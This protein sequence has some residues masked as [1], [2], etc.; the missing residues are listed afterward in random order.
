LLTVWLCAAFSSD[1]EAQLEWI[2]RKPFDDGGLSK[3]SHLSVG[4]SASDVILEFGP[5]YTNCIMLY[6]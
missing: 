3:Q 1:E 6:V 4:S 2:I 5:R